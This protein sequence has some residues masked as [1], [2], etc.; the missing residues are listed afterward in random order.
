MSILQQYFHAIGVFNALFISLLLALSNTSNTASKIVLWWCLS[1]VAYAITPLIVM[2]TS[3]SSAGFIHTFS[4]WVPASFGALFYLY[5]I[6]TIG[7]QSFT[8][9]DSLDFLPLVI[10]LWLNLDYASMSYQ[11]FGHFRQE[12]ETL[13]IQ[14]MIGFFF[15]YGQA[16]YFLLKSYRLIRRYQYQ[17][18]THLSNFDPLLFRSLLL[19][20]FANASLWLLEL[21][22]SVLGVHSVLAVICDLL[23]TLYLCG[24][25]LMQWKMP[26]FLVIK[27]LTQ[28]SAVQ[29]QSNSS[30]VSEPN[31]QPIKTDGALD[32]ETSQE[33]Y[34]L[35]KNYVEQQQ[36]FLDS[37]LTITKL[38]E[39]IG[40]SKHYVSEAINKNSGKNFH[41]FI[42]EYRV[43]WFCEKLTLNNKVKLLDLALTS[44]FSS[45][46]SFNHVF[47]KITGQTPSQFKAALYPD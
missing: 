46:S 10:C 44:G 33:I 12:N 24:L 18:E 5:L 4:F 27:E 2:H 43:A 37:E 45:K 26:N 39:Q 32:T 16:I 31:E 21:S 40:L 13:D 38:S 6:F 22:S 41:Q 14:H 35:T 19:I 36:S 20:L 23:F 42:N 25:G 15:L 9:R 7:G 8:K 1:W 11:Q 34:Q 29:T 3:L 30:K 28:A 17:A 47:K